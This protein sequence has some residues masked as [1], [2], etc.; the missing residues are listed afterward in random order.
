MK[1]IETHEDWFN[2]LF[3]KD[4][5]RKDS[6]QSLTQLTNKQIKNIQ[7]VL[8][9]YLPKDKNWH[10]I[11]LVLDVCNIK[12]YI[13]SKLVYILNYELNQYI[14]TNWALGAWLLLDFNINNKPFFIIDKMTI[15]YIDS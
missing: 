6:L 9:S 8:D 15:N 2:P 12:I 7:I 3:W 14:K 4:Y 13:N 11:A 5:L 1:I 10:L